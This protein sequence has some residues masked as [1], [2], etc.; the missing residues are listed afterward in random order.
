MA[1]GEGHQEAPKS[2]IEELADLP[3]NGRYPYHK[4]DTQGAIDRA[5]WERMLNDPKY[6]LS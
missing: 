2:E 6:E 4:P 3:A 5:R 1:I